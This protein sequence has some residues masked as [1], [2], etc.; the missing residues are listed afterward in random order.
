MGSRPTIEHDARPA[1]GTH[2][3]ARGVTAIAQG[4]GTRLWQGTT[5]APE[6]DAHA[7]LSP[8]RPLLMSAQ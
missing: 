8:G 3:D 2:L 4:G 5:G 6:A 1:W 7:A